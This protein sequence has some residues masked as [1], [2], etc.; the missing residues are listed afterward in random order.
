MKYV[1]REAGVEIDL[2]GLTGVEKRF[3]NEAR[4]RFRRNVG[5]L[6][7]DEFAFGMGSP[8]YAQHRSHLDVVRQPLYQRCTRARCSGKI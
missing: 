6:D 2:S 5:W 7:F 1:N 3:Y 4:R 8:I